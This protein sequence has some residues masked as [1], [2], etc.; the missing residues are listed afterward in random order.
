ME[1]SDEMT[2]QT[3]KDLFYGNL[4]LFDRPRQHSDGY[5]DALH[6]AAEAREALEATMTDEQKKLLDV[7]VDK[8]GTM[9]CHL[10]YSSFL[11]GFKVATR[12]LAEAIYDR[13]NE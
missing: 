2:D 1:R 8:C 13:E 3:I 11:V 10:E 7:Y 6:N 12:L 9:S 5:N 4:N